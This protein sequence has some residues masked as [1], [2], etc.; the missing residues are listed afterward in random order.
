MAEMTP[1]GR[2]ILMLGNHK[3]AHRAMEIAQARSDWPRAVSEQGPAS[4]AV[5]SKRGSIT[6]AGY[7][8]EYTDMMICYS[9]GGSSAVP[10]CDI[11]VSA[12]CRDLVA[13]SVAQVQWED[14]QEE[15]GTSAG[16]GD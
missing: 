12:Y 1:L 9:V 10:L 4:C 15:S 6:R 8:R 11:C 3:L 16:L 2:M 14:A 13:A 7:L 5:C